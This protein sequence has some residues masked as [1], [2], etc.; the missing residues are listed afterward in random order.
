MASF[1]SDSEVYY[2]NDE[3]ESVVEY[4]DSELQHNSQ[5]VLCIEEMDGR[6]GKKHDVDTRMFFVFDHESSGWHILGKRT[7]GK[8][9]TPVPFKFMS[10]SREDIWT[11]VE[12]VIGKTFIS[13]KDSNIFENCS[14]SIL[15][16]NNLYEYDNLDDMTYEF[17][18]ENMDRNY[19]IAAYDEVSVTK[20]SLMRLLDMMEK[21]YNVEQV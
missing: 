2:S 18:E 12:F 8:T 7:D 16:Y 15:N 6:P 4:L 21:F 14:I 10:F 1:D 3:D 11:F 20:R 19:E 9:V 17:L 13:E 5:M